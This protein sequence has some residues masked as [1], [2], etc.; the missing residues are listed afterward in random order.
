MSPDT[1]VF[2][3]ALR[4][5]PE[6]GAGLSMIVG[7]TEGRRVVPLKQIYDAIGPDIANSLP[8]FHA[9]TGSDTTGKFWGKGK[10][11]CWNILTNS[12]SSVVAAFKALGSRTTPPTWIFTELEEYV[13]RLYSP[14]STTR[15]IGKL[16]WHLFVRSQAE[17]EKLPPTKEA[18]RLHILRALFQAL[19]WNLDTVPMPN[20]PSPLEYGWKDDKGCLVPMTTSLQPA[21]LSVLEVVKCGCGSSR[22]SSASCTC[23]KHNLACTEMCRCEANPSNCENCATEQI[24]SDHSD[25]G[26]TDDDSE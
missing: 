20:I 12:S 24:F 5:Q 8:G 9:F 4:R 26:D 6:L 23:R 18:L 14:K 1:D 22:C 25:S 21:P 2:I 17:A 13:C 19:K 10:Q 11:S 7:T 16:R 15:D 3:L